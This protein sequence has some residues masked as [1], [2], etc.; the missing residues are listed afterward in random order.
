VPPQHAFILEFDM[1]PLPFVMMADFIS[2]AEDISDFHEPM[3]K[4]V[5]IMRTSI[6]ENFDVGGRPPWQELKP[7]TLARKFGEGILIETGALMG[8]ATSEGIWT[9]DDDS[10]FIEELPSD[11]GY[12][13]YHQVGAGNN[14]E[15]PFLVIQPEDEDEIENAF[16]SWIGDVIGSH[17]W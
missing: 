8:A 5:G 4:V 2:L 17:G 13:M 6:G 9:V 7:E 12:G 14:P 1:I 15:R 11:V 3:R 16:D 10:A